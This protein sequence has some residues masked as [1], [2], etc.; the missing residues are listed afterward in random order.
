[1][2]GKLL[3]YRV[4]K[5]CVELTYEE[6]ICF[7]E[8]I[9]NDIIRFVSYL[10]K[11]EKS[12]AIDN[13]K[14]RNVNFKLSKI[15]DHLEMSTPNLLI[16]IY[17]EFK[18]DIYNQ[19]GLLICEDYRGSR[20]PFIRHA[21]AL[22]ESEEEAMTAK[23]I[24]LGEG[25]QT[26][27]NFPH[28]KI[29]II[30][31]Y[32]CGDYFYGL[33][34][35]TGN[36]NKY[37]YEYEMWNTDEPS[38][39]LEYFK[40]LYK[41]VPFYLVLNNNNNTDNH[42]CYGIFFDNTYRTF[43]D[44]G[45]ENAEYIYFGADNGNLDYYFIY[46]KTLKD[47]IKNYT[48][49]T[50]TTP[51]PAIKTLGAHQSRW[52]YGTSKRV[53]QII[54]G[55]LK[56]D[57][58][59]DFIHLDIDYMQDYKVFTINNDRFPNIEEKIQEW[60]QKGI[61]LI[62]IID[63]GVKV[64]D[65]YTIYEEGKKN[66]LFLTKNKKIYQNRVWP[67][68]SVYPDFSKEEC[69]NWWK[70][71]TKILTDKKIKGIWNDM[72]EP[73]SFDGPLDDDVEFYNDGK[74]ANH[75]K[76]H[77]V[78]GHLMAKA[79]YEG[80]KENTNERPFVLTRAAYAGTQK[81]STFWTGDNQSLWIHLQMAIPMLCNM[82]M[83]GFS[84]VGTDIGG[85]GG[86]VTKELLCRWVEVGA[87]FPLCRNHSSMMTKDQE[88]FAFDQE[89]LKI[90]QKAIKGRYQ[91]I[92]YYYDLFYQG[93]KSGLPIIRPLV[94]NYQD[95]QETYNL[96][97]EFM[98]GDSILVS[99]V[100]ESGKT[101]KLVYLPSGK[102]YQINTANI[103]KE[104]YHIASAHLDT[105]P[106]FI[107]AGSIIPTY[108]NV[109]HLSERVNDLKIDIYPGK[110]EKYSHLYDDGKTFNYQKDIKTIYQFD[111]KAKELKVEVENNYLKYNSITYR[112]Y[113]PTIKHIFVDE[114][115]IDFSKSD[116]YIEFTLDGEAHKINFN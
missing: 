36:L 46:G 95:D 60:S 23:T 5:H 12:F 74:P 26:N 13:L 56:N 34:E 40:S 98:V 73:A 42:Y 59:L 106:T 55:F 78:Y 32:H 70:K 113:N 48:A 92:P 1:M 76:M 89:T 6:G 63:P 11:K 94:L 7:V 99:P 8:L 28:H 86:D 50:G 97:D 69:R 81:Y 4:K 47:I 9:N 15:F 62:T 77:N 21:I 14:Y 61:D 43:F 53:D 83:S 66:N 39:H 16:K 75:L 29:E 114:K 84:F 80:I 107:K 87:F 67:G 88:P 44:M 82:G 30:K 38:A 101:K 2:F 54:E 22:D 64:E 71:N 102:W 19:E 49:L 68:I 57:I 45:K 65:G 79:T 72:N 111:L 31:K 25:H 52:S 90:Y 108:Q 100:L 51:L 18:I 33:G 91:L 17:D 112:I 109:S 93:E 116:H 3:T 37:G 27:N 96:N 103:Y 104:G 24:S 58:P 35:K 41:S 105:C 10:E 110:S 85:F 20:N 115:E